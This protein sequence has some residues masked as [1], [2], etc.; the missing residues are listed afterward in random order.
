MWGADFVDAFYVSN[1]FFKRR[2]DKE[3]SNAKVGGG[4]WELSICACVQL[5]PS[6]APDK[7]FEG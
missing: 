5:D 4:S 7:G 3:H 6:V 1:M 2:K